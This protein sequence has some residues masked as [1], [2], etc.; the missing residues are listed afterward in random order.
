MQFRTANFNDLPALTNILNQAIKAGQNAYNSPQTV[1]QRQEWLAAHQDEK[2]PV[3]VVELAGKVIGYASISAYRAGRL[4]LQQTVE[5]S[6]YLHHSYLR[7]G[8]GSKLLRH[9][10]DTAKQLGYE[11]TIAILFDNNEASIAL[12][13][14]FDFQRW[15]HLP[16]IASLNRVTCGHL[17]YGKLL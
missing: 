4:A 12:L 5:I 16:N 14:R 7:Q 2:Y 11:N 13:E 8:I 3:L 6:Y 17:I 1:A 9:T 10:L 15:G